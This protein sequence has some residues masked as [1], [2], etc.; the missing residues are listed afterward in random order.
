MI[1]QDGANI[2]ETSF[3][4]SEEAR[5]GMLVV[6]SAAG[7]MRLLV[8]DALN[9]VVKE[10]GTAT[11]VVISRGPYKGSDVLEFFFEDGT[12]TPLV[13]CVA[14]ERAD[15]LPRDDESGREIGFAAWTR[16]GLQLSLPGHYLVVPSLP[17]RRGLH[18]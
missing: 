16:A 12:A 4:D 5:V 18:E 17:R 7:V 11:G 8:P 2:L 9:D 15:F 1:H 3:W 14:A 6:S 13:I 10:M